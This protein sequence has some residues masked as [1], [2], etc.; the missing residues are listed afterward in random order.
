M[1]S[2]L[3]LLLFICIYFF[4]FACLYRSKLQYDLEEFYPNN[5]NSDDEQDKQKED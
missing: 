4:M 2:L 1:F 5:K 3:L